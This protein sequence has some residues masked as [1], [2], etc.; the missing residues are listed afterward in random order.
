MCFT[1]LGFALGYFTAGSAPR[2]IHLKKDVELAEVRDSYFRKCEVSD[3]IQTAV[4]ME[5][6]WTCPQMKMFLIRR[7][8]TVGMEERAK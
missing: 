8:L 3:S 1:A 4:G 5:Q 7:T 2:I 6:T